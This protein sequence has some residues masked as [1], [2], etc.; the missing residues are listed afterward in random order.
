MGGYKRSLRKSITERVKIGQLAKV[1]SN[2][3]RVSLLWSLHPIVYVM[4]T[5]AI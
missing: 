1:Y 2:K 5:S 4:P 3:M